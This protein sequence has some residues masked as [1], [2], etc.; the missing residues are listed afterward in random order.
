MLTKRRNSASE[1][2]AVSGSRCS[3]STAAGMI[4]QGHVSEVQQPPRL[5]LL[6]G[7]RGHRRQV[8]AQEASRLLGTLALAVDRLAADRQDAG[9]CAVHP[10]A[11]AALAESE[12]GDGHPEQDLGRL[13]P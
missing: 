8:V 2:K 13:A 1:P 6:H 12:P 3:G 7:V 5:D 4:A 11:V 10:G 9:V